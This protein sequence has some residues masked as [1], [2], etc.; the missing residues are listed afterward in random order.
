MLRTPVRPGL[1]VQTSEELSLSLSSSAATIL[2]AFTSCSSNWFRVNPCTSR[3]SE[4][5]FQKLGGK[6]KQNCGAQKPRQTTSH[7]EHKNG[8]S[9]QNCVCGR[10]GTAA[11]HSTPE[12]GSTGVFV[13]ITKQWDAGADDRPFF[14][15]D[16]CHCFEGLLGHD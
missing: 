14:V 15:S 12:S 8:M 13:Y 2:P 11:R 6:P 9:P 1:K 3:Q 10:I 16:L 5:T 7:S 4:R